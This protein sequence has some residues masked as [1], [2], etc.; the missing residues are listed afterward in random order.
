MQLEVEGHNWVKSQ[1]YENTESQL[2]M[3]MSLFSPTR[4]ERDEGKSARA[5]IQEN[6]L[7]KGTA[8]LLPSQTI[9][10][11]VPYTPTAK[12]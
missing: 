11:V 5:G 7:R 8:C 1:E 12:D 6:I 9:A 10:S 3:G 4:S 2:Q